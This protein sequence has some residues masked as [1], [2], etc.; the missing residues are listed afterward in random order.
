MLFAGDQKIEHL[1]KD[2]MGKSGE[3][4]RRATRA[5]RLAWPAERGG[6][7]PPVGEIKIFPRVARTSPKARP[8][9]RGS[10]E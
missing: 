9:H 10:W 1:N 5:F 8:I 3:G 4:P 2:S 6:K 7:A